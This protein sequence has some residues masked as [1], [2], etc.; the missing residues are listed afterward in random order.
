[1]DGIEVHPIWIVSTSTIASVDRDFSMVNDDLVVPGVFV[2]NDFAPPLVRTPQNFSHAPLPPLYASVLTSK[3]AVSRSEAVLLSAFVA[4]TF[5]SAERG[6]RM[7]VYMSVDIEGVAGVVDRTQGALDGGREY[8][9]GRLLM[10]EETNAAIRARSMPGQPRSSSTTA[11][12]RCVRCSH[13][14]C[15]RRRR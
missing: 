1:M 10:T 5:D 3:Q 7:K 12:G 14:S 8:E 15:T 6:A 4:T 9:L 11:T 2:E 13:S